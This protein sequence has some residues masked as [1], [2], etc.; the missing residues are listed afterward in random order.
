M[1]VPDQG[2]IVELEFLK[3]AASRLKLKTYVCG[4]GKND[5]ESS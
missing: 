3:L 1:G 5:Q 2:F 4:Q